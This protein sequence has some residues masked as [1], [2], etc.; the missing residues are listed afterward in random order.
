LA[1]GSD[2]F[3]VRTLSALNE[4]ATGRILGTLASFQ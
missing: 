2:E 1:E 3:D 4:E